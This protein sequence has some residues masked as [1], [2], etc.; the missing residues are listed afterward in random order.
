MSTI[1]EDITKLS[2]KQRQLLEQ[3]LQQEGMDVSQLPIMPQRRDGQPLPLSFAQ[4][5]LWFFDQ[6]QP[7]SPVFNI[8]RA[9]RLRGTLNV[10]AFEQSLQEIVGRHDILRTTFATVD[11]QPAQVVSSSQR[12][13]LARSNI[14]G[15][16]AA[17]QETEV[18]RMIVEETH[19]PFDLVRGPLLRT[20]LVQL[21]PY[22]YVFI[23]VMHH[24][25]SDGWS[26]SVF[27][28]ELTSLYN[29]YT[30]GL[31]SPLPIPTLQYADFAAWQR[32][33]LQGDVLEK[34]LA[35]WKPQFEQV[36]AVL[37][38]PTDRPR[39]PLPTYRGSTYEFSLPKKLSDQIQELGRQ[40]GTTL[41]MTLLAAFQVLLMRH[42]NQDRIVVGTSIA[43][44]T[45]SEVEGLIG[46]FFNTL[47][48]STD[49]SGQPG[50]REILRRVR[51]VALDAYAH[52]ELPFE[53]LVDALHPERSL[54]HTPLFQVLFELEN[55]PRTDLN[56]TGLLAQPLAIESRTAKFDLSLA[57]MQTDQGLQG[58]LEY[59]VELFTATTIARMM[60]H[61][62]V[63]L[64]GLVAAPDQSVT[65]LPL[66]TSSERYEL[67]STR[68]DTA[69]AYPHQSCFHELFAEQVTRTPQAIAVEYLGERLTYQDL[70]SR[71]NQLAHHL[72]AS[73]VEPGDCV[74][75]CMERSIEMLVGLLGIFKAGAAFLP[76]D[77]KF[78]QERLAFMLEDAHVS[79]LLIQQ[80]L[81]E[82]LPTE[83]VHVVCLDSDWDTIAQESDEVPVC[84]ITADFL[85]YVIY[86]SGSTGKP[87]G[88]L[89][90]HRGL[91]NYL[92][93]CQ[94]AY[95]AAHGRGAPVQSSIAADAIFPS[96]FA[97]LLVG[98]SVVLLPESDGLEALAAV[99]QEKG[100]FSLMK[101]T[102]TQLEV[103][104]QQLPETDATNWVRTL[105]AGAEALR[106]DVLEYWQR[107][108]PDTIL[109]NEYGPTETVVGCSIYQIP[110][111]QAATGSIPIGLPIANTQFY[112]L[113]TQLQLLP[114]GVAGELY[115]GGDGVAWGYLNRPEL[116]AC[117]FVPDPFSTVPG[118]RLYKTGDL[119]RYLPD[120][121]ADIEFL[122]RIDQQVKIRGYRVEPGEIETTLVEHHAIDQVIVVARED[123]PSIKQLVAYL[124]IVPGMQVSIVELRRYLEQKLPAYMVP[125]HFFFLDTLP[126]KA[127]GKVDLEALP[128]PEKKQLE[129]E[130]TFVAPETPGEKLL[131]DIWGEVLGLKQI[132]RYDNFFEIGGDSIL[133]I[134]IIARAHA[135]GIQ[136]TPKQMFQ[137]QT[138]AELAAAASVVPASA[139]SGEQAVPTDAIP[140]TPVQHWFFEH[141][142]P[143]RN[144]YNHAIVLELPADLTDAELLEEAIELLIQQHDSFRLRFTAGPQGWQQRVV[145]H[146]GRLPFAAYDLSLLATADQEQRFDAMAHEL[147]TGLDIA[148]GPIVR[149]GL[150]SFGADQP[151][152]LLMVVHHLAIDIVSWQ[153]VLDT[154]QTIYQQL[155]NGQKVQVRHTSTPFTY[156]ANRLFQYAQSPEVRQEFSYWMAQPWSEVAALPMDTPGENIQASAQVV[157]AELDSVETQAL[158]RE[159]PRRYRTQANDVLLAALLLACSDWTGKH[160]LLVDLEGHG[161]EDLMD[162]I[163]LSRTVGWFTSIVPIVLNQDTRYRR[164]S[165]VLVAVKEHLRAIPNGGIGF[166]LLQSLV[167]DREI[168]EQI[169]AL[170]Q[171][172]IIFNYQ[173]Q[174][175]RALAKESL[176]S[177]SN[178]S[179]GLTV[180]LDG[181]R[182]HLLSVNAGTIDGVL[183]VEWTY[184]ENIYARATIEHLAQLYL[185][186]LR[187]IIT[188]DA[189]AGQ[190]PQYTPGD[191]MDAGLSQNELDDL[192]ANL[193]A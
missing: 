96:L 21:K 129:T 160:T 4:Q 106:G 86:T 72:Q 119:V 25:V 125:A 140:L 100:G 177:R 104:N 158:L 137:Y 136:L 184:S 192:F 64:D 114:I 7:G 78:P 95:G 145:A 186:A 105:V 55:A 19:R 42:S 92:I 41:F 46:I 134:R 74:G 150:F 118:A 190:R 193:D 34:Q 155:L 14:E 13:L 5:R 152:R 138:I 30:Q 153:I 33:W 68:N 111:G 84:E 121:Q 3:L 94:E 176:F 51:K 174:S 8:S 181:E 179:A 23:L 126:L 9:I 166:G 32:A 48:F 18:Q 67:V 76:L 73:G 170:P 120:R 62:R 53:Q 22:E 82:S 20:C 146:E 90:P 31:D 182:S 124:V 128:A 183:T 154:L 69:S 185:D 135:V 88:V 63:L 71:S 112:V 144:H 70:H 168:A 56:F 28:H 47:A 10:D 75:F 156:W 115:I 79:L 24:I 171:A 107:H 103:L 89:I 11:G 91:V 65:D 127:T 148:A 157:I 108:A 163:D 54:Q 178:A 167:Q 165:E 191:F 113:D 49:L 2:T 175:S 57:M 1:F 147:Q 141:D 131:A 26:V 35:Y 142:F 12:W 116:T 44:R 81:L 59:N 58:T 87:K 149:V 98:T 60:D 17:E 16:A 43:N 29:A 66:L 101:I 40:E 45:R 189:S 52:Q 27:F 173:G 132:G 38:L 77:R 110:A 172:Q 97:P 159:V 117:S 36:P 187:L 37:Q 161:R 151:S 50:F 85:A 122:G 123:L 80:R 164:P 143:N 61:F 102:P 130:D 109:L 39:T 83:G 6:W 169:R 139:N 99:L 15:L 162:G 93:W 180:A 133:S 188:D